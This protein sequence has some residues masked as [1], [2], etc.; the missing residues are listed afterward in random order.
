VYK[1]ILLAITSVLLCVIAW[2]DGTE[3]L[4]TPSIPTAS[5]TGIRAAGIG[6]EA[7]AT[8]DGGNVQIHPPTGK[9]KK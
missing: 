3:T 2:A 1:S 8:L 4:G 5:G 7:N 6:L 9:F